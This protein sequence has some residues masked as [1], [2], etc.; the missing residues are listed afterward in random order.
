[1]ARIAGINVPDN[2]HARVSLTYIYGVGATTAEK[3]CAAAGV[4]PERRC[5]P[6]Q[7]K[8]LL[9]ELALRDEV[10][11]ALDREKA[12]FEMPFARWCREGLRDAMAATFA[13]DDAL[14]RVGLQPEA[15]QRLWRSFLDDAP[16]IYWSRVW[17]LYILVHWCQAHGVTR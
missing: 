8:T 13:D 3:I 10:R 9:K 5:L 12:G 14:R 16:G 4:D 15:V 17:S 6:A 2:K 1:M 11:G 7:Q